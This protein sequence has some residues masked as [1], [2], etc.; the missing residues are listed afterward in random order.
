MS[1]TPGG[2]DGVLPAD[3]AG[4]ALSAASRIIFIPD[5]PFNN[6]AKQNRRLTDGRKDGRADHPARG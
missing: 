6:V 4:S 5:I 2:Q 3:L 1:V